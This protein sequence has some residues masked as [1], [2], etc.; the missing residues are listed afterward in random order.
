MEGEPRADTDVPREED[1]PQTG[2]DVCSEEDEPRTG[3]DASAHGR[4]RP[5]RIPGKRTE[6]V[7]LRDIL[8]RVPYAKSGR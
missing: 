5:Q 3:M 8:R 7:R 6:S 4:S 1:G 2:M